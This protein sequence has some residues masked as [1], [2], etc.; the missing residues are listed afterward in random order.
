MNK[1]HYKVF[2]RQQNDVTKMSTMNAMGHVEFKLISDVGWR[3][4]VEVGKVR[5][6]IDLKATLQYAKWKCL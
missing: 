6:S 5:S 2:A 4:R 1:V 3:E